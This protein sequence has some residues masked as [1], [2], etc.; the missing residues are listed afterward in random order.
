MINKKSKIYRINNEFC[1]YQITYINSNLVKCVPLDEDNTDYQTIQKW[2][3]EGGT[4]IDNSPTQ[5]NI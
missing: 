5:E 4:V 2:I 3:A 1:G